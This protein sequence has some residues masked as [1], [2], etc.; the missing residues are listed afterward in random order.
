MTETRN[1]PAL[2]LGA[3]GGHTATEE[4]QQTAG[5]PQGDPA[6]HESVRVRNPLPHSC[7]QGHR[8]AGSRT[9]HCP[10][11]HRSFSGVTHFDRHRRNGQCLDP[12]SVGLTL[13]AGRNFDCWGTAEDVTP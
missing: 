7:R 11:C 3:F 12:H 9:C 8:W 13:L 10:T 2:A 6:T 4:A 1:T 5:T